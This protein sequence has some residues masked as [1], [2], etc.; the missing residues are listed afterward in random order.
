MVLTAMSLP[1]KIRHN[2]PYFGF[3][4]LLIGF[5][6]FF[7]IQVEAFRSH[8]AKAR[9]AEAIESGAEVTV[10]DALDG[11]ELL[12][13]AGDGNGDGDEFV[14]RVLGIKAFD[15]EVNDPQIGDI[16]RSAVRYLGRELSGAQVTLE[17]EATERDSRGRILAYVVK[18]GTD[19]GATLIERGLALAFIRYPTGREDEYLKLQ[20]QA[21]A[22]AEGIWGVPGATARA[23]SLIE[24]WKAERER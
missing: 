10:L 4:G 23:R 3:C 15:P 21:Q 6:S 13:R 17:I 5:S 14:V 22:A 18:D 20:Q 11:D 16:G 19:V 9:T 8:T 7:T 1:Q 12:V 2:L 24:M